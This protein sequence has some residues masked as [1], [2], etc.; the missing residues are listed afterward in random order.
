[1]NHTPLNQISQLTR[2]SYA[3]LLALVI[4]S[5][6]KIVKAQDNSNQRVPIPK[7]SKDGPSLKFDFPAMLVGVAE[8]NECP[9]SVV[10]AYRNDAL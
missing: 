1:M 2:V 4:C 8:Y 3:L 10:T 5:P 7:T 6:Q 9:S